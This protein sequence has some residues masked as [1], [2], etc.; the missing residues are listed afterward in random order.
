[1]MKK[2]LCLVFSLL[3]IGAVALAEETAP[4]TVYPPQKAHAVFEVAGNAT[5]GYA[6]SAF[7]V[8]NGIVEL[9]DAQGE[10]TEDEHEEGVVGIGGTYRFEITA[11]APGETILALTH[12]RAVENDILETRAYLIVCLE[13]GTLEIRDLEGLAPLQGTVVSVDAQEHTALIE[14]QDQGQ[15]LARFPEDLELPTAEENLKIWFNGIMTMSLPG[16][17]N[18]MGWETIAPEQARVTE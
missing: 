15:V 12:G 1:M 11:V 16:Q 2:I 9:A 5:T 13:D 7:L 8:R 14:T 6:W 17:I 3:M 4:F 10:Y 18:V